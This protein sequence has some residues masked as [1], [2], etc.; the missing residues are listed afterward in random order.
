MVNIIIALYGGK[1]EVH[2]G[3]ELATLTLYR[4][5]DGTDKQMWKKQKFF[6]GSKAM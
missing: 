5:T 2:E 3:Q 4:Y 6:L 1:P